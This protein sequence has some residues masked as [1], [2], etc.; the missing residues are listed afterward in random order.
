MGILKKLVVALLAVFFIGASPSPALAQEA[1]DKMEQHVDDCQAGRY[2]NG[3]ETTEKR[4]PDKEYPEFE[5]WQNSFEGKF[6]KWSCRFTQ[7][8]KH[9]LS[10]WGS[11]YRESA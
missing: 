8:V 9:P 5:D 10:I 2:D 3:K 1:M 6:E 7:S 11:W 4:N